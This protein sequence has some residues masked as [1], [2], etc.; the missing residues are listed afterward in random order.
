MLQLPMTTY[1]RQEEPALTEGQTRNSPRRL[2]RTRWRER[3]PARS[4]FCGNQASLLALEHSQPTA[5]RSFQVRSLRTTSA[6]TQG[7]CRC[8]SCRPHHLDVRSHLAPCFFTHK[9]NE[10][11]KKYTGSAC[12]F[13]ILQ[14]RSNV[15]KKAALPLA[16]PTMKN[17]TTQRPSLTTSTNRELLCHS[18]KRNRKIE[19]LS[20]TLQVSTESQKGKSEKGRK[21]VWKS[22][23]RCDCCV[24][25]APLARAYHEHSK[26]SEVNG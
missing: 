8:R 17:A 24:V 5:G 21:S 18:P 12:H 20:R 22:E 19:R 7:Q 23:K 4:T 10:H 9:I 15:F 2:A 11:E 14:P 25:G 6:T 16:P 3:Y 26:T 1:R 13:S